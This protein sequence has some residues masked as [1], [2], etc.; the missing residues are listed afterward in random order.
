MSKISPHNYLK[1]KELFL[2]AVWQQYPPEDQG[3]RADMGLSDNHCIRKVRQGNLEAY[4]ELV[5]RYQK[6]IYNLMYRIS[7]SSEDADE[8]TQEVFCKAFEKLES[9]SETH[10]F[11]PWLYTLAM[12]HGRDWGRR[13]HR[14]RNGLQHY[15][16]SL[17]A[18]DLIP[19]T[20]RLER[21][22][23]IGQMFRA[24]DKL[25]RDRQELLLL[26]YQQELSIE[27][28][29]EIFSI[30]RSGVKMRIHRSLELLHKHLS[31]DREGE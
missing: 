24:L 21:Q 19:A 20:A 28:L 13:Q 15:A 12:N 3:S 30:S 2:K 29:G 18:D 27:E 22:Q 26:R 17:A 11:F 10:R 6:S 23:E 14:L 8:L 5:L 4:E 7:G 31:I 9:F 25:P 1:N 16:E